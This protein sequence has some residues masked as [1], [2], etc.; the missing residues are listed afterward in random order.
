[1]GDRV[2]VI[3]AEENGVGLG[4]IAGALR[5]A[6]A[7]RSVLFAS[8]NHQAIDAVVD[9]FAEMVERRPLL[10][11][12]NTRDGGEGFSFERAIDAI[13]ARPGGTERRER[14]AASGAALVRL[15]ASRAA[16]IEQ[17]V[18]ATITAGARTADLGGSLGTTAMADEI[19]ARLR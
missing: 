3:F 15:D 4:K 10:I 7:G 2:V 17:A 1:M 5:A 11:R 19:I 16:A 8:R 12:A 14:L 18:D 9:R 13:L 6:L